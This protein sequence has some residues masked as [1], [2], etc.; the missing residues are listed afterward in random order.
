MTD[1]QHS[2]TDFEKAVIRRL[3]KIDDLL[4]G[5]QSVTNGGGGGISVAA[6]PDIHIVT[7]LGVATIGVSFDTVL[8]IHGAA[9]TPAS[10][11]AATGAGLTAAL[12]AAASGDTI[13]FHDVTLS[14][15]HTIPAGVTLSGYDRKH[16]IL[17][18]KISG[19]NE[20]VLAHLTVARTDNS[21]SALVG[22]AGPAGTTD[23]LRLYDCVVS[24]TQAGSG[25]AY[26]LDVNNLGIVQAWGCELKGA[27]VGGAGYGLRAVSGL[28]YLYHGKVYGSTNPYLV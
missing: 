21:G 12:A 23:T 27:S 11:F 16:S 1:L 6:G 10:E 4:D 14:G 3:K 18:G 26:A 28:A 19:G 17:S 25:A 9:N 15:D 5:L 24:A 8:L 2:A 20:S 13:I 22:V 7:A